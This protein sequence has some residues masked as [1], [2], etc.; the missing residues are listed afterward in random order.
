MYICSLMIKNI[1]YKCF[2][3]LLRVTRTIE[4]QENDNMINIS[5]SSDES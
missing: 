4:L 1:S 5:N 2:L 3:I